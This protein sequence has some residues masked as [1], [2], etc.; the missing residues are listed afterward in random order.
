MLAEAVASDDS[1]RIPVAPPP[2]P[3]SAARETLTTN[4]LATDGTTNTWDAEITDPDA[5]TP[6]PVRDDDSVATTA[7]LAGKRSVRRY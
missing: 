5:L 1:L 2:P 7:E 3:R 6:T 4:V